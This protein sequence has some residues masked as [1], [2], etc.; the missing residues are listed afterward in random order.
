MIDSIFDKLY[1]TVGGFEEIDKKSI[2]KF[3][4]YH[5]SN[6]SS[7][8]KEHKRTLKQII[9]ASFKEDTGDKITIE[10]L[11]E[12]AEKISEYIIENG[13]ILF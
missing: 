4:K 10:D 8:P 9:G 5:I 12:K 6:F 2:K 3:F 7:L 11:T 13:G 1:Q